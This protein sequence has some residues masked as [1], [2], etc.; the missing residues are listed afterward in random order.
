LKS[1]E[2]RYSATEQEALALKEGLVEFQVYLEGTKFLA[3]TDH[4]ALTWSKTYHNV[5]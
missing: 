3:I 1:A 2:T 4:A 5:N